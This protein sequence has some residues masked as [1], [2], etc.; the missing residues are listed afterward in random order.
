MNDPKSMLLAGCDRLG[1]I[2][3]G[4][5]ADRLLYYMHS[6][7]ETNK[8]FN[9]TGNTKE[10]EFIELNIIDSLTAA[11]YLP[12]NATVIDIGS[13][14][15][16]PGIPLKIVRDDISL[17]MLDSL[18][19]RCAFLL[20]LTEDMQLSQTF[21]LTAR[22]EEAALKPEYRDSF[23]IAISRAVAP[24]GQLCELCMPFVKPGGSFVAMKGK[25]SVNELEHISNAYE[26]LGFSGYEAD[27]IFLPFSS[28]QR[29]IVLCKKD[30][31]TA[32][33]YPRRYNKIS[34]KPLF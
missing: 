26:A 11:K 12:E 30:L 15:G 24:M 1:L 23:D 22:A 5:T 8:Q 27:S 34:K 2:L 21:V 13:G 7:L 6:V 14:C 3:Q 16:L 4:D 25:N 17:L 10:D 31:P 32:N 9:L 19:K 28:V 29:D 18:E 20:T 33:G